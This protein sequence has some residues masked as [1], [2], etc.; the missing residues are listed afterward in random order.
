MVS[1]HI[2]NSKSGLNVTREKKKK[3]NFWNSTCNSLGKLCNTN[4]TQFFNRDLLVFGFLAPHP[5]YIKT[6]K[7]TCLV[8][9]GTAPL[10]SVELWQFMPEEDLLSRL[11]NAAIIATGSE[12][13]SFLLAHQMLGITELKKSMCQKPSSD[14]SFSLR[15]DSHWH[16]VP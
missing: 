9:F 1:E 10:T 5:P 3:V 12:C 15:T 2:L 14:P 13:Q 8:E 4:L 6:E 11:I 7:R 16:Q